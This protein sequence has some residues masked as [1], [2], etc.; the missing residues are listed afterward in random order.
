MFSKTSVM[1][2][3][4]AVYNFEYISALENIFGGGRRTTCSGNP[5][6]K[7]SSV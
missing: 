7:I 2:A 3:Q 5:L 6:E 1:E 4:K